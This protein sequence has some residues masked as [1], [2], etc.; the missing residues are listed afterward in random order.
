MQAQL[1]FFFSDQ[2]VDHVVNLVKELNELRPTWIAERRHLI[3]FV[4][5]QTDLITTTKR[6]SLTLNDLDIFAV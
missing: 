2:L 6:F 4:F 1:D 3:R 5:K